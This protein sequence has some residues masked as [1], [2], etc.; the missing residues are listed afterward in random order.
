MLT[1]TELTSNDTGPWSNELFDELLYKIVVQIYDK[2]E[3][4]KSIL[5]DWLQLYFNPED[6]G[7]L[8]D[9]VSKKLT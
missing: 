9:R 8:Q 1:E 6:I 7:I 5:V 4:I 2:N 3:K